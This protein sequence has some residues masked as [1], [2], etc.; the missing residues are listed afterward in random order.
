MCEHE[1]PARH[2]D[3]AELLG[4]CRL[5]MLGNEGANARPFVL[6]HRRVG[7]VLPVIADDGEAILAHAEDRRIA[8]SSE[9][10]EPRYESPV[11]I[12]LVC[13]AVAGCS[14]ARPSSHEPGSNADCRI[15]PPI[16]DTAVAVAITVVAV[17][18]GT[19]QCQQDCYFIQRGSALPIGVLAASFAVGATY[20]YVTYGRCRATVAAAAAPTA[21]PV[22][23]PA[24][25]VVVP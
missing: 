11:K 9:S 19:S 6:R 1:P 12:A 20:G 21:P 4:S 10:R 23:V 13:A 25:P 16:V 14:F 5:W 22:A 3:H 7:A 15:A 18:A 8:P 2:F 17:I 24:Q